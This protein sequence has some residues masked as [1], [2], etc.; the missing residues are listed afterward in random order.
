MIKK[1]TK[2]LF[3]IF[4]VADIVAGI[5]FIMLYIDMNNQ[6]AETVQNTDEIKTEITKE[7][8]LSLMKT[9]IMTAKTDTNTLD[10]FLLQK[11][12]E[13][14]FIKILE[15]LAAS[16]SL[17][18][19]VNSVVD[20]PSNQ[21]STINA[22][23]MHVNINVTGSWSHIQFFLALLETYPLKISLDKIVLTQF[24]D[25]TVGGKQVPE[26]LGVFDFKVIRLQ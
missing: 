8:T 25:T 22:E 9:D 15:S 16:S 3:I 26:W 21:L 12:D 5:V 13:V 10:G 19:Q 14:N 6:V 1:H 2:I 17:K 18:L 23:F 20:E 24:A 4:L 7:E 11:D